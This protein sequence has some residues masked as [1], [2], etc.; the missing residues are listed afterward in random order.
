MSNVEWI[1][2]CLMIFASSTLVAIML[3][4]VYEHIWRERMILSEFIKKE[5]GLIDTYTQLLKTSGLNPAMEQDDIFAIANEVE[6]HKFVYAK[7]V[8][9]KKYRKAFDT[10]MYRIDLDKAYFEEHKLNHCKECKEELD[11]VK[12]IIAE[13]LSIDES[14]EEE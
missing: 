4:I 11:R 1:A 7:L 2:T 6:Y 14:G 8:E 5:E 10:I 9:L 3:H 12:R 13:Y